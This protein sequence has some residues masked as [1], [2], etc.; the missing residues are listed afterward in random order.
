MAALL[1]LAAGAGAEGT[2]FN[3]VEADNFFKKEGKAS[4]IACGAAG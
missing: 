4:M 2:A 3:F 1:V